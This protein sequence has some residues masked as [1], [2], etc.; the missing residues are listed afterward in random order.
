MQ[1]FLSLSLVP[2]RYLSTATPDKKILNINS[3]YIFVFVLFVV[4]K[5]YVAVRTYFF[6]CS[7]GWSKCVCVCFF[8]ANSFYVLN[9]VR[10]KLDEFI[11]Y[12]WHFSLVA[13]TNNRLFVL[14]VRR[15]HGWT[16]S[17]IPNHFRHL[18]FVWEYVWS[19]N[20]HQ[21]NDSFFLGRRLRITRFFRRLPN[22]RFGALFR[23]WSMSWI[24]RSADKF[25]ACGRPDVLIRHCSKRFRFSLIW[26]FFLCLKKK[27]FK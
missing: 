18:K 10:I 4:V 9:V 7:N 6:L 24:R 26:L 12:S 5:I 21:I 23:G 20:Q 8:E 14:V 3:Y 19:L 1:H 13:S 17:T 25:S 16:F 2:F 27:M 22:I 11:W 15:M